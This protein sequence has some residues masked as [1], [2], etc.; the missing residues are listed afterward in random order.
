MAQTQIQAQ[1]AIRHVEIAAKQRPASKFRW[2]HILVYALLI[3][4]TCAIVGSSGRSL[5]GKEADKELSRLA[6]C[7]RETRAV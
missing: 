3:I 1:S 7:R 5:T 2:H 4:F 6:A